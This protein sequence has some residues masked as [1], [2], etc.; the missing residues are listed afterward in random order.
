MGHQKP[1]KGLVNPRRWA[2]RLGRSNRDRMVPSTPVTWGLVWGTILSVEVAVELLHQ[3]RSVLVQ[4][5]LVE[6]LQRQAFLA[7]RLDLLQPMLL[8]IRLALLPA[9]ILLLV[10]ILT[11]SK[12][13]LL[14][15]GHLRRPYLV[16]R[17]LLRHLLVVLPQLLLLS[18]A[19]QLHLRH[20]LAVL[21]RQLQLRHLLAA[22]QQQ[23][24][25][26]HPLVV[27]QQ[28]LQLLRRLVI[29]ILAHHLRLHL[30][31]LLLLRRPHLVDPLHLLHLLLV[32]LLLRRL[33]LLEDKLLLLLSEALLA[34]FLLLHHLVLVAIRQPLLEESQLVPLLLALVGIRSMP[35]LVGVQVDFLLSHLLVPAVIKQRLLV[36]SLLVPLLLV[37]L[38]HR[39]LPL[40]VLHLGVGTKEDLVVGLAMVVAM[41]KA[42]CLASFLQKASA[43]LEVHVDSHT[44]LQLVAAVEEGLVEDLDLAHS[45]D[46]GVRHRLIYI[47][48]H[49]SISL[50]NVQVN[51]SEH[52]SSTLKKSELARYKSNRT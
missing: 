5:T 41:P 19:Q 17:Q 10:I 6:P 14:V 44:T 51:I 23:L 7:R 39:L 16:A 15:Q 20:L 4:T 48:Q 45:V 35:L 47:I 40:E 43:N 12:M 21:R 1:Q 18:E 30:G 8:R 49:P 34:V 24:H 46:L 52:S 28:Q 37:V 36:G 33:P 25:L 32:D 42:K 31:A 9:R 22:L 3:I 27:L 38:H 13:V 50:C 29:P 2:G 11:L 26:R